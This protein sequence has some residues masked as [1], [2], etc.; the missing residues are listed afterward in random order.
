MSQFLFLLS[1]WTSHL[2]CSLF[3][4]QPYDRIG[5]NAEMNGKFP[6]PRILLCREGD[7]NQQLQLQVYRRKYIKCCETYEEQLTQPQGTQGRIFQVD[8]TT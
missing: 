4:D 1:I 8:G 3:Q 7:R 5:E 6:D 2:H